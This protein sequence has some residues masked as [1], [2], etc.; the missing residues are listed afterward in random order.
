MN[1]TLFRNNVFQWPERRGPVCA[2]HAG[3]ARWL[4]HLSLAEARAGKV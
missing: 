1:S 4:P 3:S 2:I